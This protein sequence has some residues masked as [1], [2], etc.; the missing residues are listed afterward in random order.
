L[1]CSAAFT[2]DPTHQSGEE[3]ALVM[4]LKEV[5]SNVAS[6]CGPLANEIKTAI[7][8]EHSLNI[9]TLWFLQPRTVPK[10]SS[11]KIA[12]AWCRKG[13]LNHTL[14][15][16]HRQNFKEL[17]QSFEIDTDKGASAAPSKPA[18]K[19]DAST[20]RAMSKAEILSRLTQDVSRVGSIPPES[21]NKT[22]PLVSMLDS[23]TISQFK[24]L[25][26]NQY[27]VTLS[28]EYLFRE[29]TTLA[30]LVEVVKLGHAPDDTGADGAA[31]NGASAASVGQ[32]K[33]L[34]G[35][36]GCPPGVVC[37]IL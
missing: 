26:E 12:R 29:T 28:D 25:L 22:T 11:G 10:T 24:G 35:A 7:T 1:G 33:G 21:L 37:A 30:K 6:V 31:A 13:Y 2:I 14:K 34:A 4:E 20:I 36:M 32:A 5:P 16:V 18:S 19:V 15:V 27:G 3:V 23:L 8:Q 17:N 9:A